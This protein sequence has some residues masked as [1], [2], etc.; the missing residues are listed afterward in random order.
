VSLLVEGFIRLVDSTRFLG[1]FVK[2]GKLAL[3]L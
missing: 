1:S 2:P 3:R